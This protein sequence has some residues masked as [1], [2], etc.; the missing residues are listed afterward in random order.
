MYSIFD[1][2][3]SS[4]FAHIMEW[5][6]IF[7]LY[8]FYENQVEFVY[9]AKMYLVFLC[10]LV[11]LFVIQLIFLLICEREF[12]VYQ[13]VMNYFQ[14]FR[15]QNSLVIAHNSYDFASDHCDLFPIVLLTIFPDS[16]SLRRMLY[17]FVFFCLSSR[18]SA[19]TSH[20]SLTISFFDKLP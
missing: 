13:I 8:H 5:S 6:Y 10:L 9:A 20:K 18:W 4:Y 19:N 12:F 1:Y 3:M 16:L 7:D 14:I 11:F 17:T 2:Y 15:S